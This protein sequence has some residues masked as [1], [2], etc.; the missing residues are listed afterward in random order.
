MTLAL[1]KALTQNELFPIQPG[2]L[3][4]DYLMKNWYMTDVRPEIIAGLWYRENNF[5]MTPDNPFQF[6]PPLPGSVRNT[7]LD[8]YS[9][10]IKDLTP[11]QIEM[12]LA[13]EFFKN[14]CFNISAI[15]GK[16]PSNDAIMDAYYG[17]NGRAFGSD[18]R[19]SP[20]VYNGFDSDHYPMH[21]T[22]SQPDPKNHTKRI[23]VTIQDTRP[24]A[25]VVYLQL[26][27]LQLFNI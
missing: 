4:H 2:T 11:F 9:H 13:T 22:G 17:Y 8:K 20:Y 14:K 7:L 1:R 3:A 23:K 18:P 25:F 27:A 12:L 5:K 10:Y 6:D 26:K 19:K 15:E 24:G 21:F 16:N